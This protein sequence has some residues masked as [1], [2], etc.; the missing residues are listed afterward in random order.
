MIKYVCDLCGKETTE[1]LEY[2]IPRVMYTNNE[3]EFWGETRQKMHLC[4]GCRHMIS[5]SI[6]DILKNNIL[7][8]TKSNKDFNIFYDSNILIDMGDGIKRTIVELYKDDLN[9]VIRQIS[10]VLKR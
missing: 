1:N 8:E 10:I 2:Y 7:K 3:K 4:F 6:D 9:E 5:Y